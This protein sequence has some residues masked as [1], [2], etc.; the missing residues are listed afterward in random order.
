MNLYVLL[1][2]V[3]DTV[4]ELNVAADGK[5]LDTEFLRFKVSDPDEH[6]LEQ[7]LI[8][9]EKH[10]G[11]VTVVALEAPE[12][13]EVLFTALAK[14]ADRALKITTDQTRLGA[15]AA[16][17]VYAAFFKAGPGQITPETL[18]LAGSQ[19]ID[20]LEGELAAYLAETLGLPY[21]G[22]VCNVARANG[23]LIVLKEFAGGLRGQFEIG[24]PAVLGVQSAEKPPRYVPVAK[25]RAVMKSA[26]IETVEVGVSEPAVRLQLERLYKPEVAGR[27]QMLEGTPEEIAEK[28]V[29]VLAK[30]GIL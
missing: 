10:G 24:L 9:K 27:A 22:V 23:K 5:S 16:A 4:E 13:D 25:V 28:I 14:G 7:A 29:E 8:L 2:M 19:A 11:T 17:Q 15:F 3:P 18:I 6:A 30:Q 1:K 26:K 21:L 20:D 12:V